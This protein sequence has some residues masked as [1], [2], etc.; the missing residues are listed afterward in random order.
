MSAAQQ[1]QQAQ[2]ISGR[3]VGR[4]DSDDYNVVE[5]TQSLWS[6]HHVIRRSTRSPQEG[7]QFIRDSHLSLS[8][9]SWAYSSLTLERERER[10]REVLSH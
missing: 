9:T 2:Q 1:Q 8:L 4:E 6:F 3:A 7:G 10:A 5:V